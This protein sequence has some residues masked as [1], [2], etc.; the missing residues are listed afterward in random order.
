MRDTATHIIGFAAALCALCF[1]A[2][3]P[4]GV[5]LFGSLVAYCAA[6]A[7]YRALTAERSAR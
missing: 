2:D 4:I 1:L 3:F 6:A 5:P 7:A